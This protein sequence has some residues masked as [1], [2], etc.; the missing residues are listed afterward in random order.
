MIL[1]KFYRDREGQLP[2][3]FEDCARIEVVLQWTIEAARRMMPYR[4][5]GNEESG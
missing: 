1:H 2:L 4:Y 5:P 3:P